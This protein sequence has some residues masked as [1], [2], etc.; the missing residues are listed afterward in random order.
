M[1]KKQQSPK[2]FR[3]EEKVW[4]ELKKLKIKSGLSWDKFI[5]KVLLKDK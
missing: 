2:T 1:R 3:L 4:K 5:L